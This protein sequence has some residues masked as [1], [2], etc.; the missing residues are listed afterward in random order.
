MATKKF[1][2]VRDAILKK[3]ADVTVDI[4]PCEGKVDTIIVVAAG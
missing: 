2:K 3:R 1:S 4:L